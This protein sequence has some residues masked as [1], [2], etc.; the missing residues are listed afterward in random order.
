MKEKNFTCALCLETFDKL[1]TEEEAIKEKQH[2]F[3]NEEE[4]FLVC[5]DCFSMIMEW[6]EK[7]IEG[8]P[9]DWRKYLGPKTS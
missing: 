9:K 3:P 4:T 6:S 1:R 5:D 8:C 2:L 7:N